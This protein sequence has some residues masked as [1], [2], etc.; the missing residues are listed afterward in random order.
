M[1]TCFINTRSHECRACLY[2]SIVHDTFLASHTCIFVYKKMCAYW[3][4]HSI[5]IKGTLLPNIDIFASFNEDS[6]PAKQ[7]S[8]SLNSFGFHYYNFLKNQNNKPVKMET[9]VLLDSSTTLCSSKSGSFQGRGID[10]IVI[11]LPH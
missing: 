7:L 9:G 8:H 10:R 4:Y 6:L 2:H 11:D 5:D 3:F 1:A